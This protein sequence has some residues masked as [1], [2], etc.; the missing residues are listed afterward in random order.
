[1]PRGPRQAPRCI[2]RT[3]ATTGGTTL[4][5]WRGPDRAGRARRA[6][7]VAGA[8]RSLPAVRS[9]SPIC[10]SRLRRAESWSLEGR[11][12]V[13]RRFIDQGVGVRADRRRAHRLRV[14]GRAA[15]PAAAR[16]PRLRVRSPIKRQ[17]PGRACASPPGRRRRCT[18]RSIPVGTLSADEDPPARSRRCR[19]RR[20][21]PRRRSWSA[22][23]AVQDAILIAASDGTLAPTCAAGAPERQRH[24]REHNGRREQGGSAA[25]GRVAYGYF[26]DDERALGYTRGG[27]SGAHQPRSRGSPG[28]HDG[29]RARPPGRRAAARGGRPRPRRRLQPWHLGS[30]VASAKVASQRSLHDRR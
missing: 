21:D 30:A 15:R 28:R 10:T 24:R 4:S 12:E 8:R 19:A 14:F 2:R 18:R 7:P 11:G 3:A 5:I 29:C 22:L 20:Q 1:M 6:M 16:D 23:A 26:L 25:A 17:G 9:T 27:A 13:G